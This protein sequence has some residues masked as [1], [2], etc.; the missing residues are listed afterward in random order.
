MREGAVVQEAARSAVYP[1]TMAELPAGRRRRLLLAADVRGGCDVWDHQ[2]CAPPVRAQLADDG[3]FHL[4]GDSTWFDCAS[5]AQPGDSLRHDYA[6]FEWDRWRTPPRFAPPTEAERKRGPSF[7]RIL[8]WLELT[9]S[10]VSLVPRSQRCP[11]AA[12]HW[13]GYTGTGQRDPHAQTRRLLVR[14]RGVMCHSCGL[15]RACVIDHD[16]DTGLVRGYVCL[17]CNAQMDRCLHLTG[18]AWADYLNNPPA[19]PMRLPYKGRTVRIAP[20]SELVL[21]EREAAANDVLARLTHN[22]IT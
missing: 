9:R 13:P 6:T 1:H 18:C 10:D 4:I 21:A 19:L 16:H 12:E 5:H 15:R 14:H 22:Q 3:R 7:T 20:V 8:R 17:H 11:R 2:R